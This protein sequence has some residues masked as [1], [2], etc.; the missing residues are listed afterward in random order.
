MTSFN[1]TALSHRVDYGVIGL[2]LLASVWAAAIAFER[3]L[4]YRRVD[5]AQY[6]SS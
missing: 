1:S 5:L 3:R 6:P 4:F 2:L